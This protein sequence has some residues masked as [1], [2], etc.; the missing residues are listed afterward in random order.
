MPANVNTWGSS[1][2]YLPQAFHTNQGFRKYAEC[3]RP[4]TNAREQVGMVLGLGLM[5]R[6]IMCGLE[7]EPGECPAGVPEYVALSPLLVQD[8]EALLETAPELT[9]LNAR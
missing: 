4:P 2:A 6:D 8:V 9:P 5:I 1:L 7:I 3:V